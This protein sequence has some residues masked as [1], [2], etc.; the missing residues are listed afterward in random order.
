VAS[1]NSTVTVG[2]VRMSYVNVWEPQARPGSS[3]ERYSVTVLLPKTN[4]QAKAMLDAAIN[5]AIEDGVAAKWNGVRPPQIAICVHDG[6]GVR[7]SDGQPY[8]EECRGMWVFT[9]TSKQQPFIVDAGV[10]PIL[11]RADVY[12]GC[13]G[14]VN[15]TFFAYN[16]NGRK[17][18]GCALNGIQKL[19]DDE[20][21]AGR[22]TPEE[23]FGT[24]QPAYAQPAPQANPFGP[25]QAGA[26]YA[27]PAPQANPFAMPQAF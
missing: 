9:A 15:V 7:P 11:N 26:A 18:I 5:A 24:P 1:K 12:S 23:A 19:R 6:D 14:R 25:F 17:G 10:Q 2:E 8:G 3:D 27:Q 22:I 21:L 16:N 4:A 20:P 13:W